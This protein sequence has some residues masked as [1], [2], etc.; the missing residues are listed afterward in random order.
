MDM[1]RLTEWGKTWRMEF[2]VDKCEVI[3]FG[4]KNTKAKYYLNGEK[5][6]SALVERDLGVLVHESER[7]SMKVQRVTGSKMNLGIYCYSNTI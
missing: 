4:R 2:N 6:Q 7:T 5:L 1:D 3:H